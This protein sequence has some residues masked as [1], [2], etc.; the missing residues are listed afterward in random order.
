MDLV[1]ADRRRVDQFLSFRTQKN[2]SKA[3]TSTTAF[4]ER[5]V[6]ASKNNM[7]RRSTRSTKNNNNNNNSKSNIILFG[8]SFYDSPN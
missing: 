6:I 2:R 3:Y 5:S 1:D 8:T 7:S 4:Q